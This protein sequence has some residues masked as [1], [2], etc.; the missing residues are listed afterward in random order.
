MEKPLR[1][2]IVDDEELARSFLREMLG[3]HV[4]I[5]VVAPEAPEVLGG[6]DER[7]DDDEP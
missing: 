2:I 4:D 1:A 6:R 7:A 3:M 5:E